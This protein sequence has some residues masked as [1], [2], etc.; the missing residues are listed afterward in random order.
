MRIF[1][2]LNCKDEEMKNT[3]FQIYRQKIPQGENHEKNFGN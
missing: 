1:R 2:I 3:N